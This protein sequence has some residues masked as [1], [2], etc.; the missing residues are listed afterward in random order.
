[1]TERDA[2]WGLALS[3]AAQ[4]DAALR[5]SSASNWRDDTDDDVYQRAFAAVESMN[6]FSDSPPPASRSQHVA[7]YRSLRR[8]KVRARCGDAVLPP[9]P[10]PLQ[11]P[12]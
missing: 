11:G 4:H 1:M 5:A 8:P 3:P 2:S 12:V 7:D 9:P 10:L 6:F